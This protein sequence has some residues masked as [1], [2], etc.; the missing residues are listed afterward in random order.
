MRWPVSAPAPRVATAAAAA[1]A[2]AATVGSEG[3]S[4]G[5]PAMMESPH[6]CLLYV[7][8]AGQQGPAL[9][10]DEEEV[11][12]LAYVM[13]DLSLNKV[14]GV[15]QYLVK[16]RTADINENVLSEQLVQETRLTEE[17]VKSGQPLEAAIQAF[18]QYART[19]FHLGP[20]PHSL[21]LVTDGQLPLRQCLHP[22]ACS[23]GIELPSY[24]NYFFDLRKEFHTFYAATKEINSISDMVKYLSMVP[25]TEAGD[26]YVREV[27]DMVNITMRLL[28]DGHKFE[29]PEVINLR[30]E[31][32]ICSK[33]EEVDNNCVVRA[34]GLPWQSSDQDIAKFFRGLNVA[35]GG[36]ALCLSPQGRRNGEA[37]VRFVNQ[38]HRDMALKRHKH[39]IG[40]RYIEVYRASGEDFINVA[41]GNNNEAQ[42]F[43]SRGGQ[44]I[45]RMRGLPYDCTAK[46]VLE[47]FESGENSCKV[48]DDE[49]GVLFVKKPDGRATGDAFVLFAQEE[50]AAKALSKHRE[51]IG[52]RYIE[53]FRSTTAEVQQVLNRSMDPKTYEQQQPLIAQIPQVPLLPQ[54]IITSGTRKDCI[55]LRGLPYEAQ[56]EHILEFLG[57]HA[58]SIVFQG[59]HMVYN[60]QGQPSG[61]AFIQMDSEQSAFL[62]AQQKHHRYMTFGKKQRYIEVFQCSG[63]DMNLVLTGG[64]P[65]SAVSP[66]KAAALLSPG[67]TIVAP[68]PFGPA[69]FA[70]AFGP[71][72]P[73]QLIPA[74]TLAPHAHGAPPPGLAPRHAFAA[75]APY[76]HIIYWPYP[77]PPVSPTSYYAGPVPSLAAAPPPAVQPPPHSTLVIMQGLP[78]SANAAHVLDFFPG[79]PELA[80]DCIQLQH[81]GDGRPA[82]EAIVSF[83]ARGDAERGGH[84]KSLHN[85]GNH[86][87]ELFMVN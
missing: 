14:V 48:M 70:A 18:D 13:I 75:A 24:Y 76:P 72:G 68:P 40:N 27:K 4:C 5:A 30:L 71:A 8:T 82:C 86:C 23:K 16:P 43:L 69:A 26:F 77:S 39:H 55:R 25:E 31:P 53:L 1:A 41:G 47:F 50:D 28:A 60:A 62:S 3:E 56:V 80:P 81:N 11:V 83:S 51:L 45:V 66:A 59:V 6:L 64:I 12:L 46:Q 9:G 63:E 2:A 22:E 65:T 36:V 7:A 33:N 84:E 38:E 85:L 57:E 19:T 58:K 10:A 79:C 87:I 74:A 35:K 54:H 17:L 44:V 67:G 49:E 61:E 37:L 32:G 78:F 29:E 15:N 20:T 21:R 34:R 42:A 52:S 73:A